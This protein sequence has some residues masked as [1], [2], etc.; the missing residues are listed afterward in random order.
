MK[1]SN[2]GR[3]LTGE[4]NFCRICG[5]KIEKDL[6][7]NEETFTDNIDVTKVQI[8][9]KSFDDELNPKTENST[10][11]L[12]AMMEIANSN[13]IN[14]LENSL[15]NKTEEKLFDTHLI[16]DN[17]NHIV[18]NTQDLLLNNDNTLDNDDLLLNEPTILV[19]NDLISNYSKNDIKEKESNEK[20]SDV[21]LNKTEDIISNE[22]ITARQDV[23]DAYE[24]IF[25]KDELVQQTIFPEKTDIPKTEELIKQDEKKIDENIDASELVINDT[26]FQPSINTEITPEESKEKVKIIYKKKKSSLSFLLSIL[27]VIS[28]F[29]IGYLSYLLLSSYNIIQS[30]NNS[31]IRLEDEISDLKE[32]NNDFEFELNNKTKEKTIKTLSFNKYI[33]NVLDNYEYSISDDILNIKNNDISLDIK[34]DDK[35]K[36]SEI[37]NSLDDYSKKITEKGYIVSSHGVKVEGEREYIFYLLNSKD[38]K[39]I[40][41]VYSMLDDDNTI[42]ILIN[43]T[44]V[45]T[46]YEDLKITNRIIE[47][48]KIDKNYI[49]KNI[50]LFTE[51]N[52]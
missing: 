31:N 11:E 50:D 1:C 32:K 38:E 17:N 30:V 37:K 26:K 22:N 42:G 3:I 49:E 36:Y 52:E 16:E 28:L 5:N 23:V 46:N 8:P 25:P 35:I 40:L 6:L 45:G 51:K 18:Q 27:F 2:C 39:N 43:S 19:P 14:E 24:E 47:S 33:L 34:F 21:S 7:D 15:I 13:Q 41:T 44:N 9:T 48:I 10:S 4:E 29:S 12:V 20:T